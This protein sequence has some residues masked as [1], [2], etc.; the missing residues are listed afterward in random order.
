M[1]TFHGRFVWYELMTTDTEA[2]KGFYGEVAGWGAQPAPLPGT[3]YTLFTVGATPECGLMKQPEEACKA[4]AGPGDVPPS[5]IGYVGVEDVDATTEQAK[6]LG[7]AV[8]MPPTDIPTVGRF[9]VIADPQGA[10]LGLFKALGPAPENLPEPGMPGRHGWHELLAADWEK[11]FAFY[12]ALFGWQKAEAVDLGAMGV[13]QI[14]AAGGRKIGGMFTKPPTVPAP[15]WLYY[16]NVGDIDAAVARVT[17]GGGHILNG[18]MEVPG[19][20]WIIQGKDP[21]GAMF[22]LVGNCR[23][24]RAPSG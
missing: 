20:A 3:A 23:T 5:W 18:P 2:A 11:A 6:R 21:Q 17:A 9:S 14:F 10:A 19:G 15:F 13:Y 24:P 7:G 22:A 16:I 1:G 4:G 8:Y 12:S